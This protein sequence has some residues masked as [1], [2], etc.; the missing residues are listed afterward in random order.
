MYMTMNSHD[1]LNSEKASKI[2]N[3]PSLQKHSNRQWKETTSN[4]NISQK[5]R[6]STLD[7]DQPKAVS[8]RS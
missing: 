5:P 6:A 7:G 8:L 1:H 4:D 3:I 2:F